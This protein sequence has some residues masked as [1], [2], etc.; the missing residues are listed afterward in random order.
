M[1]KLAVMQDAA[2]DPLSYT[3]YGRRYRENAPARWLRQRRPGVLTISAI[4]AALSMVVS[5]GVIAN[6]IANLP[7]ING[8]FEPSIVQTTPQTATAE[9]LTTLA[10]ADGNAND[11]DLA[12]SPPVTVDPYPAQD[13]GYTLPDETQADDGVQAAAH[14]DDDPALVQGLTQGPSTD[15]D[16]DSPATPSPTPSLPAQP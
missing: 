12:P 1:N 8:L 6:R 5:G 2:S 4:I 9:P 16:A 14:I 13:V 11:I 7:D 3:I 15:A 10:A